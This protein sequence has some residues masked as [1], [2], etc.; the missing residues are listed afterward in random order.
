MRTSNNDN[1]LPLHLT[2]SH[3]CNLKVVKFIYNQYPQA[4]AKV[5]SGGDTVLHKAVSSPESFP[6]YKMAII[7]FIID[8]FSDACLIPNDRHL[9]PIHSACKAAD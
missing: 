9:L 5:G 4:F 7:N 8:E 6:F 1:D 2:A 3:C